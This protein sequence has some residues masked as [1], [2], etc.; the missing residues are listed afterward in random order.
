MKEKM[1]ALMDGELNDEIPANIIAQIRHSGHLQGEW[2]TYHL[3]GDILRHPATTPLD[4]SGRVAR[5]L[6][7][8]PAI[9]A[10]RSRSDKQE[11]GKR[12]GMSPVFA[13]AASITA[14]ATVAWVSLQTTEQAATGNRH[15]A[16]VER[17][18]MEEAITKVSFSQTTPAVAVTEDDGQIDDYLLAHEEFSHQMVAQGV[19]HYTRKVAAVQENP[20][21]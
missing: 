15:M 20:D 11:A 6:E 16:V 2:E 10:P 18:M 5:A 1:S 12:S 19:S 4:I 17:P 13:V 8:E 21:R 3:I 9:L 7:K 14:V